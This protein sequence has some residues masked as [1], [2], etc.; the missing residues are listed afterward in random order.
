M[1]RRIHRWCLA[2]GFDPDLRGVDLN[3]WSEAAAREATPPGMDIEYRTGDVFRFEPARPVQFVISS[4]FTHHLHDA[5]VVRFL[6]WMEQV[7]ERGWFVNDLHRHPVPYHAFRLMAR[8]ARWHRFVQHDGPVS[9]A[10][11]FRREDWLRLLDEAGV[12]RREAEVR[13]H[14]PF[15][16]SVGRVR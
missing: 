7:A 15:R 2:R 6:R 14:V 13:W 4:L 5:E 10:R 8:A 11:S 16:L 12:P 3:P 1:L 9:I